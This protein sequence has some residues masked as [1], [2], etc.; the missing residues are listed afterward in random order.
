MSRTDDKAKRRAAWFRAFNAECVARN[1]VW[2]TS[3]PNSDVV[4]IEVTPGSG[5]PAELRE[6]GFPLE[7]DDPRTGERI[8]GHG[9]RETVM[10][11]RDGSVSPFVEGSTGPTR[12]IDHAG[13]V[14]VLR[15]KFAAP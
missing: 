2:C 9:V 12:V 7:P 1:D 5:F 10:V 14:R 8:L 4:T 15:F 6:R 11:N 3:V 13:L